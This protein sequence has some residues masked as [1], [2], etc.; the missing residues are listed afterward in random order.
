MSRTPVREALMRLRAE[1]LVEVI[2]RHGKHVLPVSPADMGEMYQA[3][4]ALEC[5]AAE[6][7]ASRK[8]SDKI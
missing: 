4:S 7:L 6:L 1:G 3:L 8:L 5:M 2:P